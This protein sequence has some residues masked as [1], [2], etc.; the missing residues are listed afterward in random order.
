LWRNYVAV[1][2]LCQR[3]I[4]LADGHVGAGSLD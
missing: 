2:N 1:F 3:G 4:D